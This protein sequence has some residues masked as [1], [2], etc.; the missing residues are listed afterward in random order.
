[1]DSFRISLESFRSF[2]G[3]LLHKPVK[4][5]E[6]FFAVSYSKPAL[7]INISIFYLASSISSTGRQVSTKA[8]RAL[9]NN[10]TFSA[11]LFAFVNGPAN[12]QSP[13]NPQLCK[14]YIMFC[15]R[16]LCK[17]NKQ[18]GN[19]VKQNSTDYTCSFA[20]FKPLYLFATKNTFSQHLV[21]FF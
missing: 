11:L 1:M 6:L 14:I 3:P 19:H 10:S 20:T 9:L 21:Y 7:D 4:G 17:P 15:S 12:R 8:S 16:Y 5:Q 18:V 13:P 2:R